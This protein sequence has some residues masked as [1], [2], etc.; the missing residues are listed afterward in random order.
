MSKKASG[1]RR[2]AKQSKG[3]SRKGRNSARSAKRGGFRQ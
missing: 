3:A 1:G 2:P